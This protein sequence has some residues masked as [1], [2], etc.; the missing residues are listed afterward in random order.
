[1]DERP[2][3]FLVASGERTPVLM[4][5]LASLNVAICAFASAE[6]LLERHDPS[7]HGC[8]LWDL[9][10]PGGNGGDLLR[11]LIRPDGLHPL[12]L[13]AAH[14]NVQEAVTAV[15]QG[16]LNYLEFPL[17]PHLL[18]EAVQDAI[19]ADH[20]ARQHIG[21]TQRIANRLESLTRREREVLER[22]VQGLLSKQIA[23]ELGISPRTVEVH[24]AHVVKKMGFGSVVQLVR[25]VVELRCVNGDPRP[26]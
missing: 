10:A 15:K 9:Q 3:I 16:V 4:Q 11:S 6:Q 13:I 12:V 1:M 14:A 23:S 18:V 17:Q 8:V 20:Q 25:A 19:T 5:M 2:T 22:V 24:R 26:R 7:Q 21:Q